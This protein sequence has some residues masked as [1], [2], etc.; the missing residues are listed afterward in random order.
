MFSS[1]LTSSLKAPAI[2][3]HSYIKDVICSVCLR[4]RP[5]HW[6]YHWIK[7]QMITPLLSSLLPTPHFC[8]ITLKAIPAY[9]WNFSSQRIF[10]QAVWF[11]GKCY[12]HWENCFRTQPSRRGIVLLDFPLRFSESLFS[13]LCAFNFMGSYKNKISTLLIIN[14]TIRF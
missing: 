2:V 3:H 13:W 14:G 11:T 12:R 8:L 1:L 5:T 9:H 4:L 7:G 6:P 10:K